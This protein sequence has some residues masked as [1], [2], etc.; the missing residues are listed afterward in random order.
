VEEVVYVSG[1]VGTR[2]QCQQLHCG[3]VQPRNGNHVEPSVAGKHRA[4]CAV[5]VSAVR[6]E[7][8]PLPEL[9]GTA[10]RR[11]A[12]NGLSP[13]VRNR[14]SQFSAEIS[15]ADISSRDGEERRA[16][17]ALESAFPVREKEQLA[18]FDGS[19]DAAPVNISDAFGLLFYT[20]SILIPPEAA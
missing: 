16:A 12:H 18:F 8:H 17:H 9:G 19:A 1:L 10:L 4:A 11:R 15:C 6:I 5:Q 3:W 13:G 20:G 2:D 14:R 7:D